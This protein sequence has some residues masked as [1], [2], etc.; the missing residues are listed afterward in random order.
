MIRGL[1]IEDVKTVANKLPPE[2]LESSLVTM[3]TYLRH[4]F[5]QVEVR[6]NWTRKHN[7]AF[8]GRCPID[9]IL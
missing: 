6:N 9:L 5:P 3:H 2:R 8:D 7:G 4:L 1:N